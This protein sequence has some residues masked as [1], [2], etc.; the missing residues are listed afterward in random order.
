[1]S[2]KEELVMLKEKLSGLKERIE[3]DDADA[4]NEAVSLKGQ[5]EEKTVAI[6]EAEKKAAVLDMIGTKENDDADKEEKT[7]TE[8]LKSLE[9]E[10]LKSVRGA[11]SC[12]LKTDPTAVVA[13]TMGVV[14][15]NIPV[16]PEKNDVRSLFGTEQIAGNSMTYFVIGDNVGT[17]A[18]TNEGAKKPQIEPTYTPNTVALSKI[19][20]HLKETDELLSDAPF[21]ESVLRGRATKAHKD[22][23]EKYLIDTILGTSGIDVTI[24]DG[25]S[26]DNLLKAK[27]AI[28][29]AT[30]FEPDAIIINP[31]DLQTLLLTKDGTGGTVGQYLMGGPAYA[32]YGNGSYANYLPIW[33]MKVVCSNK[34]TSGIALVGAFKDAATIVTKSGE[35]FRVEVANTNEDDFI[36]NMI[37]VR[38]EERLV[39]AVRVPGA[40][41]K[42][43]TDEEDGEE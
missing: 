28:Q 13:P 37:T 36:K 39:E 32:P 2:L 30:G 5:I 12:Y 4:I 23:V 24:D 21:L 35:G 27:M 41:A 6:A 11:K 26:F 38:L 40:F 43:W 3:A 42:V 9:L 34:I 33:G 10:T 15:H 17:P 31:A 18:A 7:M 22:V 14:S 29:T 1:M 19:A 25:I 8:E 16:A 20:C